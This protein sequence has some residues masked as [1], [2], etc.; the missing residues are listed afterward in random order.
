MKKRL[1]DLEAMTV[2]QEMTPEL[3]IATS[4]RVIDKKSPASKTDHGY[5][6]CVI[7]ES[8]L[9]IRNLS[10]SPAQRIS[11][12]PVFLVVRGSGRRGARGA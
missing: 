1:L 11:V 4:D 7:W 3:K 10:G 8:A 6:D 5:K 12:N 2:T 9:R